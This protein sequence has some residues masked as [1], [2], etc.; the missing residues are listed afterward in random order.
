[1]ADGVV[2]IVAQAKRAMRKA[3]ATATDEHPIFGFDEVQI[4]QRSASLL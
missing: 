4:F 2:S 1:L 3:A